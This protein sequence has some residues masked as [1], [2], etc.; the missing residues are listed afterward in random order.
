[1]CV[2]FV[3]S[4]Y[5]FMSVGSVVI[6]PVLF[7]TL[8]ICLLP[9]ATFCVSLARHLLLFAKNQ[10]LFHCFFFLFFFYFKLL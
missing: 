2:F 4:P 10:L 9:A 5:Y 6:F 7:L 1:M 8:G 3:V